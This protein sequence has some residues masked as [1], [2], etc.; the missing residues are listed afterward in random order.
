MDIE[1]EESEKKILEASQASILPLEK[2][3]G[4][5]IHFASLSGPFGIGDIGDSALAFIDKLVSMEI[6]FW[7]FLPTGPTAYGDSPYQP[8]SAF[9]GNEMLIGLEPLVRL[10]LIKSEE[11]AAL[12]GL[13]IDRVDYGQ[14]IPKKHALLNLA[15]ERFSANAS[16]DMKSAY[17]A[18]LV[19]HESHWLNDY[20]IYRILKTMHGERPWP[21]WKKEFVRREPGA[22]QQFA[23]DHRKDIERVKIIQFLF[24]RQWQ[25]L[26]R[27]AGEQNISLFGDM[28]IYI[29]LDSADAWAHPEILLID[30]NGRPSHVAGVPPDYFSADGQLWG[31]PLYDWKF[32]ESNGYQW[33]IERLQHAASQMDLVRIDHFR[34]F[35]SF[36]AVEFG[37]ETARDGEWLPGPG[38]G[39]FEAMK[40]ALG[41]LPIVAE[42][43]GVIT[44]E[45][46]GLRRRHHIPGMKVL[47]F[48]VGSP[49][50][51]LEEV[52]RNCVCYTG[53]HDN[54]TTVGWFNGGNE[55][56]RSEQEII[57]Q[58]TNAIA[59]TA[60]TEASIHLDMIRLAFKSRARL[61]VVPIQDFLGLGSEARLNI[62]GSTSN[63]WSWRVTEGQ[64]SPE[65][66]QSVSILVKETARS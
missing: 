57:E 5:G 17:E 28:P 51:S 61:A 24:D 63:N 36:W 26:R 66:C 50:F 45:V 3:A 23:K 20:A 1:K 56:T 12:A 43:L 14:L 41:G 15:A 49:D 52:G 11:T 40:A 46:D 44:P 27:Y 21:E 4:A 47:Q 37:A 48:E 59:I 9:A 8:L 64:L 16:A 13:P 34:G 35:E 60:G 53:T 33:W 54:D 10:G 38:D 62:P 39:L 7:Q 2:R 19:L 58:R 32:H 55:D 29:A 18:F 65:F 6:G 25:K 30:E 22:M 31:N 42:D